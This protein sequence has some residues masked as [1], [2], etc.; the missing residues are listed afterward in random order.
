M[1]IGVAVLLSSCSHNELVPKTASVVPVQ[2]K[3]VG[4]TARPMADVAGAASAKNRVYEVKLQ[5]ASEVAA[6]GRGPYICSPSGFGRV[7]HC[8]RRAGF[9]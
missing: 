7:S 6:Y 8:V 5:S 4:H 9:N 3:A 2:E 1:A